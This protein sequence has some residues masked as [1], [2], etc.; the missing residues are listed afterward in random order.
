MC[1]MVHADIMTYE[2]EVSQHY[3]ERIMQKRTGGSRPNHDDF[4]ANVLSG[5]LVL[6]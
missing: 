4:L 1:N 5:T 2:G 3:L 6:S